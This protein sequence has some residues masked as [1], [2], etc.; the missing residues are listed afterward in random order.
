MHERTL[1]F[2]DKLAFAGMIAAI[3]IAP[4]AAANRAPKR[5][6]AE[7]TVILAALD[8]DR[9][10]RNAERGAQP[11]E[12]PDESASAW[13]IPAAIGYAIWRRTPPL[14]RSCGGHPHHPASPCSPPSSRIEE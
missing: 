8:D 14:S 3:A 10:A 12:M 9:D 13:S 6:N 7:R 11:A 2:I 1:Q 4:I 5:D